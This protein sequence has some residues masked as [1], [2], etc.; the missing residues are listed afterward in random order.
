[1]WAGDPG[2]GD[3]GDEWLSGRGGTSSSLIC[4]SDAAHSMA[5]LSH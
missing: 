1:M 2:G 5:L 3:F 4:Y